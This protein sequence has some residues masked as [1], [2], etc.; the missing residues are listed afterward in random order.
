MNL[1]NSQ[2]LRQQAY[3]GGTWCDADNG[4]TITV[5]NPFDASVLGTVPNLGQAETARAIAAADDALPAWRAKTGK[6]R[7]A[8]LRKWHALIEAHA[9][10]LALLLTLEQGKPLAEARGELNYALSF[11]EWFAEEAKRVYG[12]VLPHTRGDQRM[13]AIRQPVGVC[14]AIIAWN[15]PSALVTR[16]V[17]PALA[18]GCTV[19]LKPSE[20]TPFTALALAWLGEQAGIPPGVLNVVIGDPAP[21]GTELTRNP[22]VRKL[23]FTGSTQ[24]GR[25]LMQQSASNIKKLSLE[26]GGNAPFIVF[27]DADLD[28]AVQGL[29]LSKFRNAGQTC[30]CA[31]RV[32]VHASVADAFNDKLLADMRRMKVGSGLEEGVTQGPLIDQ[33]AV[34]KVARL[35]DDATARGARLLAGGKLREPGTLLYEPTLIAGITDAMELAHEEIFGPVVGISTFESEAAVLARANDSASGLAAYFYTANL[36][37]VWRM[38]EGLEYGIVGVNTGAVS[39][40]VGPF[41]GIKESGVGREG[42][43]YGIEEFLE[44]KYVCLAGKSF[45]AIP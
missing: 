15:F 17:S 1:Q 6:E 40:E 31:N 43:K 9:D 14:A 24:T 38:M 44:I 5:R 4:A 22:A 26:L 13:L 35:V 10:D 18:A 3:I 32:Y 27:E 39:N 19:V 12:D 23:T 37:R 25:L 16:K 8:I 45:N 42:S 20:L 41:G 28:E 11:V 30:V 36:E 33:R 2:L 29:V 21:I 7:G 34:D